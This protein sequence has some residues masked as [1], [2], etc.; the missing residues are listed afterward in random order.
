MLCSVDIPGELT[1]LWVEMEEKWIWGWGGEMG[2]E[3]G[4]EE[5]VIKCII[6]GKSFVEEYFKN[7]LERKQTNLKWAE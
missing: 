3:L 7:I 5:T 6:F 2:V 4:R 1:L